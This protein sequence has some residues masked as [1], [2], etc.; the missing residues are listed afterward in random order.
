MEVHESYYFNK[1]AQCLSD[2]CTSL[3]PSAK[4]HSVL[5][6]TTTFGSYSK[7]LQKRIKENKNERKIK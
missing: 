5:G 3:F 4:Q 7:A 6:A 1:I 2:G